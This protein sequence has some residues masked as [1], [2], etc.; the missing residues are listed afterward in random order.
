MSDRVS[1]SISAHIAHVTLTRADKMNALDTAM[2]SAICEAIDHVA[3][4]PDVRAVVVSGEGRGFCAGLDLSNFDAAA[5]PMALM[6][7]THGIANKVQ[8]V[9]WGWRHLSVPVISA[10]HGVA[11][12]GGLN[13]MSGADIRVIHPDTRC[14]VMEM[15]WGLVPDMAGYPLW[16]GNVRDDVLRRLVF[17][18]EEFTGADAFTMGF[19]TETSEA[20]LERAIALAETIVQKNPEAIRAAKRLSNMLTYASDE[21]ILLA[22]SAEQEKIMGRPNQVEAVMAQMEGRAPSF[23]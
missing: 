12:G 22:E 6:P 9:A 23:S 1:I 19:A 3:A 4:E 13:I 5:E 8:Q 21:A 15:R 7:R 20:P 14:A 2:F 10:V 17:T 18:N 11:F 16:R